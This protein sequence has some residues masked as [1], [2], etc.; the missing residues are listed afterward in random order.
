[1]HTLFHIA[2]DT[3]VM[4]KEVVTWAKREGVGST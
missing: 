1:M 3:F 4:L 2:S